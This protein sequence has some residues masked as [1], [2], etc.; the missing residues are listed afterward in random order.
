MKTNWHIVL[1]KQ[2]PNVSAV[3]QRKEDVLHTTNPE[4]PL[5]IFYASCSLKW[6]GH[7]SCCAHML[8]LNQL[9]FV[10]PFFGIGLSQD[11]AGAR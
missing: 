1:Y 3:A 9:L 5:F 6:I 8:F 7:L 4:N 10:L 2:Y 11:T